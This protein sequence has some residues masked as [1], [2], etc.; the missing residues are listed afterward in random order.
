[1]GTD[2]MNAS[3]ELKAAAQLNEAVKE[4]CE[5]WAKQV[6]AD[7]VG[8]F[9]DESVPLIRCFLIGWS[10]VH[11]VVHEHGPSWL[12][13]RVEQFEVLFNEAKSISS[14][15]QVMTNEWE[16]RHLLSESSRLN[17]KLSVDRIMLLL[18]ALDTLLNTNTAPTGTALLHCCTLYTHAHWQL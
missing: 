12:P 11:D 16:R 13:I 9:I 4:K 17:L 6:T 14:T 18:S 3:T 7:E 2:A 15:L 5:L 1:M 10:N 8:T